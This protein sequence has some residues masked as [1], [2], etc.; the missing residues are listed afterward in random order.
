MSTRDEILGAFA[1]L[2]RLPVGAHAA[3]PADCVWAYPLA[4]AAVGLAGAAALHAP[5]T[6][7]AA[8]VLAL[9][10]AALATGGLHEDGLA[11]TVD[12]LGGGR[13]AARR[14]AILKDSRIG[15]HGALA[16]VLATALRLAALTAAPPGRAAWA[17]VA[18]SALGRTAMLPMLCALP[19]ARPDGLAA[20]LARASPAR[21]GCGVAL[22]LALFLAAA[23]PGG[24]LAALVAAAAAAFALGRLATTRFGGFTGDLLGAAALAAECA[25]LACLCRP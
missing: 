17:F 4:G 25:A 5:V 23:P 13:D 21:L 12:A 16:L 14:L 9:V 7:A 2:T 15:A 1:L 11:D 10:A 22:G 8:A 24:R 6:P 19:P 3:A 20:P 18:A